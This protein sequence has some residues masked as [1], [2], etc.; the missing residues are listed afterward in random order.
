MRGGVCS[1]GRGWTAAGCEHS[2]TYGKL[3]LFPQV[4]SLYHGAALRTPSQTPERNMGKPTQEYDDDGFVI[5][6][7]SASQ[8]WMAGW[9]VCQ[10][11]LM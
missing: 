8:V 1:I 7:D 3:W 4:L 5:D 6:D 10:Q 2:L 11:Q 9:Q